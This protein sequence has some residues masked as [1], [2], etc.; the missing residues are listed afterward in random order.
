MGRNRKGLISQ[1]ITLSYHR[2]YKLFQ[3]PKD[4]PKSSLKFLCV[5]KR[6]VKG[7]CISS[8]TSTICYTLFLINN[9]SVRAVL[10]KL[11]TCRESPGDLVKK[12]NLIK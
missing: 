2:F 12:Q 10:L 11:L 7:H 6:S 5:S 4:F 3:V 8:G 1:T 9:S